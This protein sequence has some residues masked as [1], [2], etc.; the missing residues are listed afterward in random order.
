MQTVSSKSA[1]A[2]TLAALTAFAT[3]LPAAAQTFP[4]RP[5]HLIVAYSAGGTWGD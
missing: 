1:D 2:I 3:S 5:V 4:S